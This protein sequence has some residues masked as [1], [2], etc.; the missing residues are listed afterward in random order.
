MPYV[1]R[2]YPTAIDRMF[3]RS[4]DLYFAGGIELPDLFSQLAL[5][6]AEIRT[7]T[8]KPRAEAPSTTDDINA[9]TRIPLLFAALAAAQ[10]E[11]LTQRGLSAEAVYDEPKPV[12]WLKKVLG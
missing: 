3:G 8:P 1:I 4:G 2:I 6:P 11:A 10:V 5:R 9:A 12:K 7:T